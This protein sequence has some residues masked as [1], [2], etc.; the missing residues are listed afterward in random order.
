[1][2]EE[3]GISFEGYLPNCRAPTFLSEETGISSEGYVRQLLR[4]NR[5]VWKTPPME[6]RRPTAPLL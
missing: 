4:T 2:S 3:T 6:A 5:C 1:L